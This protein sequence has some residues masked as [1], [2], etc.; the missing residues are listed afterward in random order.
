MESSTK[1]QEIQRLR[2]LNRCL[3]VKKYRQRAEYLRQKKGS[4]ILG[5]GIVCLAALEPMKAGGPNN[6]P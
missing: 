5:L 3:D 1:R 2:M 6:G 4:V